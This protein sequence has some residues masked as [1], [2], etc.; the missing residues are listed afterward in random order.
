M[1]EWQI[2][3]SELFHPNFQLSL[4][5]TFELPDDH[6]DDEADSTVQVELSFIK[7]QEA[8]YTQH[9]TKPLND[10]DIGDTILTTDDADGDI[11]EATI[12]NDSHHDEFPPYANLN[13]DGSVTISSLPV[14][15]DNY[16]YTFVTTDETGGENDP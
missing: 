9:P 10:Y 6:S 7:D 15:D 2:Y 12:E 4:E 13:S 8:T 3:T 14:N 1:V 11:V 16:D 5:L